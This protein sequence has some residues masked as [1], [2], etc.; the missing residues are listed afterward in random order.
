MSKKKKWNRIYQ[1]RIQTFCDFV[2]LW[3]DKVG[4]ATKVPVPSR[5]WR[6]INPDF[7]HWMKA[8]EHEEIPTHFPAEVSRI[9][10]AMVDN[11][12]GWYDTDNPDIKIN[13][14]EDDVSKAGTVSV[15][16]D[17]L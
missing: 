14:G 4:V 11:V 13:I 3:D 6:N 9:H 5:P 8:G 12:P 15:E 17:W 16:H 7:S 10:T 2:F 1:S